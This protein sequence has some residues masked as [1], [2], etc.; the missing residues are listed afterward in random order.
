LEDLRQDFRYAIRQLRKNPGFT[1]TVVLA[2]EFPETNAGRGGQVLALTDAIVGNVRSTLWLLLGAVGLVL[3]IAC[4]NVANL[5]LARATLRSSETAMRAAL[6]AS[7]TRLLQQFFTE[8]TVLSLAGCVVGLLA[9][10]TSVR[11]LGSLVPANVPRIEGIAIDGRVLAF[12][13][14][15]SLLTGIAFGLAPAWRGAKTDLNVNLKLAGR[16]NPGGVAG[17]RARNALVVTQVALSIV[18]L[19]GA[20]LLLKSFIALR[21][22]DPGFDPRNVITLRVNLSGEKFRTLEKQAA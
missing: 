22:V 5:L 18:L 15:V 17:A 2:E 10:A 20:G 6:G 4:S 14:I 13:V 21:G 3:L 12:T 16:S 1:T 9:A 8:S 19:V 11:A 7:R